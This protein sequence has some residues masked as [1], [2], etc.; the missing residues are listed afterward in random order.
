[1]FVGQCDLGGL[2]KP[3]HGYCNPLGVHVTPP[4]K[5]GPFWIVRLPLEHWEPFQ[6]LQGRWTPP[7][8]CE[9]TPTPIHP[10]LWTRYRAIHHYC[11]ILEDVPSNQGC[12]NSNEQGERT[13]S[14]SS[15]WKTSTN[16]PRAGEKCSLSHTWDMPTM[17]SVNSP[18]RK[19]LSRQW[20]HPYSCRPSSS[21]S[22]LLSWHR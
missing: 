12:I 7:L 16:T 4:W 17:S 20:R 3:V 2:W 15:L 1:M 14:P 11:S 5:C 13:S 21:C 22:S 18:Q 8:L 10:I 6:G 9:P 19:Q